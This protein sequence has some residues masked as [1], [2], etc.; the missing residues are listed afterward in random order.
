LDSQNFDS[1][2]WA[3]KGKVH[4]AVFPY[5]RKL[6]TQQSYRQE[7]NIR[8]MRLY[9]N[10]EYSGLSAY[11]YARTEPAGASLNRVTLNVVQSMVD[12][13]VSKITKN[14]PRPYFLTDGAN[15]SLQRKAEKLTKFAEGQFYAT[16]FYAK[17]A[18]AFKDSC[19]FGTG[20]LKI[21]KRNGR[22]EV[23][24]VFIDELSVDDGE[25][26]Y[27]KPRQLHQR[28]WVHKDV[29]KAAFPGHAGAIDAA[30]I[31]MPSHNGESFSTLQAGDMLLVVE[32]WH[33]PSGPDAKDGKHTITIDNA[34]LFTEKY[35]KDYFPFVLF[36][37]NEAPLGFF[38]QGISEQLTGLQLEINKILRTIQV[39]MHLVSV[40][41]I[42]VEAG[43][44]IVSSHINNKI[45][46]IIKYAGTL[47]TEGK[48]GTIPAELFAHL[49][50][51]YQRA[52]EI[53]G[54]S[55][56]SAQSEKPA[57]LNSGKALRT[58]NDLE[59]ERFMSVGLR[60]EQAFLD[61]TKA[62]L[63]I[64]KEI[65][66]ETGNYEVKVPGS[67][68]LS[69][70]KWA[71]VQMEEDQYLLQCFPTNALSQNPSARLQEV[72]EL[73]QA[74][75]V[76]PEDGADL[77]NFPDLKAYNNLKNSSVE[78]IK[79]QI[80]LMVEEQKYS[81]PEPFQNL[82]YGIKKMQEAYLM[83][84]NQGAPDEVLE[85]FR[86]WIADADALIRN[87]ESAVQAQQAA[88]MAPPMAGPPQAAAVPEAPPTSDLLPNIPA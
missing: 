28:K 39:S 36:R 68:F 1:K 58:F 4:E 14:K 50:R 15:W 61:A 83:Y 10:F 67:G 69:T 29:L 13:V 45:G 51:L 22:I 70:I 59:T 49:D 25:A 64:G 76:G 72:Q 30:G 42:F 71:D 48:L 20:A 55:Q 47:P 18:I 27:G 31:T 16:D 65:A 17:A 87:A 63:D 7:A 74:G 41:K 40:P 3:K 35:S 86:M 88:L 80:E 34:D 73:M 66:E 26:Y 33:L 46:G 11:N 56:L 79:K 38:G 19:I 62:M 5:L 53:V 44:K 2:W 84:Q 43:S 6:D 52:F 82:P 57:G 12:T 54:V 23:E 75:L 21:F 24:R 81:G 77:L 32:S 78:N 37:W 85:L 60:Y 9:G 8:N